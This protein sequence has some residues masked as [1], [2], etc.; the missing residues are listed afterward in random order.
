CRCALIHTTHGYGLD[1]KVLG[2]V[3]STANVQTK[4]RMGWPKRGW[5]LILCGHL[6]VRMLYRC[7][8]FNDR[9]CSGSETGDCG[10]CRAGAGDGASF[11]S[12]GTAGGVLGIRWG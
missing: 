4:P 5:A 12:N 11:R 1:L 9:L 8:G 7:G 2:T 6:V 3:C 10:T